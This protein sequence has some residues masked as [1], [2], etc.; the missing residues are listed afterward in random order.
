MCCR[1]R[2]ST[3]EPRLPYGSN[4]AAHWGHL[5]EDFGK[6]RVTIFELDLEAL[7]GRA[8]FA[9]DWTTTP[10]VERPGTIV[11]PGQRRRASRRLTGVVVPLRPHFGTMGVA[12]AAPGRH[13]LGPARRPRRQHRQ[14]ADRRR[15]ADATT[16][17]RSPGALLSLG[18]P[19]VSQGDGEVSGTA[20]EASLNV[21]LR[22]TVRRDLRSRVPVLETPDRAARARLRRR[23]RR[24][25]ARR[26]PPHAGPARLPLRAQPRRRLLVH[27]R[28]RRLHRDP[29]R[30]RPPGRPRPDRQALLPPAGRDDL[31]SW[32]FAPR[33]RRAAARWRRSPTPPPPA[34]PCY[35]TGQMP[36]EPRRRAR[37]RAASR[38]RPTR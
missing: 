3:A 27:E 11:E 29:G 9:Y 10:L 17:C 33:R 23:P 18:D 8:L 14:L 25:D 6:E 28:R 30:R 2:S 26:R 1:S 12:P 24:G 7:L 5:Y 21:L 22:L 4:L 36:T 35:V 31:E 38:S 34:R 20:L 15:R 32:T 16:R 37:R 13:S 19:H